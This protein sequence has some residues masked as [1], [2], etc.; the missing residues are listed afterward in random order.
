MN[1]RLIL[2][3][4]D[5]AGVNNLFRAYQNDKTIVLMYHGVAKDH[6]TVSSEN[7]LQV[8]ESEFRKQ[9][10]FLKKYYDVVSLEH[11]SQTLGRKT[12]RPRIV[13]TF[14]DGYANNYS[15]AYPILKELQLPATIFLVTNM[16]NTDKLF[17]SDRLYATFTGNLHLNEIEK[18]I[19]SYKVKH[20]HIIDQLVDEF[21][22]GYNVGAKNQIHDAYGVLTYEQIHEMQSSGLITF[23]SHTNRHEIVTCLTNQELYES[24][25]TSLEIM[26][27]HGI[28]CGTTFCY[29][30]GY[31]NK[32]HFGILQRLG[33][34][35][36]TSATHGM[37]NTENCPYEI[38][39]FGVGR[40]QSMAEFKSLIS[41][42]WQLLANIK[43]SAL[44][45]GV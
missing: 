21:L 18:I 6:W 39:R 5:L 34:K 26:R 9:M 12:Q 3:A 30:N 43:Q 38:P 25:D 42:V 31:Y 45:P 11:A 1:R 20:P 37:W 19:E 14:D 29:P 2:R 41:G 10:V 22:R 17:W 40:S 27:G 23:D 16:I 7:W 36:A 28:K 24:I 35:L 15:V 44:T 8:K 32:E 4:L 13:I 33:F